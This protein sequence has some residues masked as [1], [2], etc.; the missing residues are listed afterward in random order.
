[1]N[2]YAVNRDFSAVQ[3]FITALPQTFDDIGLVIH[4]S[5]NVIKKVDTKH[6]TLVVKSFKGMYLF[7]RIAYS[8]FRRSKAVRSY[9]YSGILNAQGILT[10]PHVGWIDC[11]RLGFLTHS[12]FV[13]VFCPHDTLEKA[14]Q[15]FNI[16]PTDQ[17][18]ALL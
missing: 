6:G 5:R 12:Y 1:M 14:I 8:L 10:P 16:Q 18:R 3:E 7:N 9:I 17:K 2:A 4:N 11:Y 15:Y 13:S